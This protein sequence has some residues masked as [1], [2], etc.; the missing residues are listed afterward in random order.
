M[1]ELTARNL[2]DKATLLPFE[3]LRIGI[4]ENLRTNERQGQTKF[5]KISRAVRRSIGPVCGYS[6]AYDS[7]SG[8]LNQVLANRRDSDVLVL[9]PS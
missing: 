4:L 2:R 8:G 7:N 3:R 9:A 5:F 1:P 6:W